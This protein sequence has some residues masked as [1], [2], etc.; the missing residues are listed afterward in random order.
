M[1]SYAGACVVVVTIWRGRIPDPL[2]RRRRTLTRLVPLLV[3]IRLGTVRRLLPAVCVC[4]VGTHHIAVFHPVPPTCR[5]GTLHTLQLLEVLTK[6]FCPGEGDFRVTQLLSGLA[7]TACI[8][9][10]YVKPA[11]QSTHSV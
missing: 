4:T 3:R 1:R 11:R 6:I 9:G 2:P 5:E 7:C 10:C 8:A